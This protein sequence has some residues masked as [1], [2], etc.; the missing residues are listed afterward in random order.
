MERET[1]FEPATSTLARSHSTAESLPLVLAFYST[2]YFADNSLPPHWHPLFVTRLLYIGH[3]T[4]IRQETLD[5]LRLGVPC[6]V[7]VVHVV[8]RPVHMRLAKHTLHHHGIVS[9][10]DQEGES[11][12][13]RL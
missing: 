7:A 5:E 6:L 2:C 3:S 13:L 10:F 4:I 11:P 9:I 1:G 8:H 12:C